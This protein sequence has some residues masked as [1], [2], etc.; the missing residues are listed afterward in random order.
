MSLVL[1]SSPMQILSSNV[2]GPRVIKNTPSPSDES[3]ISFLCSLT[4]L[5][6]VRETL[7]SLLTSQTLLCVSPSI[8]SYLALQPYQLSARIRGDTAGAAASFI[9]TLVGPIHT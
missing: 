3:V 1:Y 5:L 9:L 4:R 8:T 6:C 7:N 2:A